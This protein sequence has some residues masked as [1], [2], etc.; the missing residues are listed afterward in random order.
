MALDLGKWLKT[1]MKAVA[2]VGA[3]LGALAAALGGQD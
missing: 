3:V 1:A 2:I